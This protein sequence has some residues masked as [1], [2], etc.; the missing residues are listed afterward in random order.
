M[1]VCFPLFLFKREQDTWTH[2][3][4]R[5]VHLYYLIAGS[6]ISLKTWRRSI[7]NGEERKGT[8]QKERKYQQRV[9]NCIWSSEFVWDVLIR[10]IFTHHILY[11]ILF[12]Y[13]YSIPKFWYMHL[14]SKANQ[15]PSSLF[16]Q[17]WVKL[18]LNSD[19]VSALSAWLSRVTRQIIVAQSG[20]NNLHVWGLP[21]F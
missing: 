4:C 16:V 21:H 19:L 12:I 6:M 7:C 3:W 10:F 8:I 9:N 5:N 14:A 17:T 2:K 11:F 1:F 18:I 15:N 20:W 13:F